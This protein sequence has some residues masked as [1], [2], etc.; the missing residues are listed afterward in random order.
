MR[1]TRPA[2][3]VALLAVLLAFQLPAAERS[4]IPAQYKWNLAD[5]YPS[6][7]AWDAAKQ[8]LATAIPKLGQWQGR[9]GESAAA[10]L[11]AMTEWDAT[12]IKTDRLYVYAFLQYDQ[13]RRIS[14]SQQ[15]K[16]EASQ[17][18]TEFGTAAAFIQ[19]EL[20][21]IGKAKIDRF[22]AE[23]PRLSP[24]RVFFD[25]TFRAAAHT[26][27]ESEEK[28]VART[29]LMS[30]AGQTVYSAFTGAEMPFPQVTLS[31]GEKVRIDAAGYI[32][33]RES[34]VKADR[35]AV[36]K[37][38][39]TSY[40]EFGS[41][42]ST[43]LNSHVNSLVF[44]RDVH[45]FPST[46][47][48]ALYADNIPTSVYTQL[49]ADVHANLPTLH[50]YLRL[51]QKIM[52]LPQLGYEDLYAP[53]V[54]SVDLEF[55]PEQAKRLTLESFAPLGEEYVGTLRKGYESGWVDFLPSTGKGTGAYSYGVYG[56]H[57][58]QLLNFNGSW[59][60]VS[61]LA[62]ESGHSMNSHLS[63]K[64]QPYRTAYSRIPVAEVASTLNENLLFH[65][66][67]GQTQDDD[68]RLFLLASYLDTMRT[69]IFRQA[70]FAEFEL[71]INQA[72][73][74]GEPLTKESL[75]ALYLELLRQYYGAEQGLVKVADLYA[76][77]WAYIPHFYRNFYVYQY[78]TGMVSGMALAENI[79]GKEAVASGSAAKGRDAYLELLSSGSSQYPIDLLKEAGVDMTTSRPFEAA[80]REM[81]RIMDEI[82]RIYA[83][84]R[85]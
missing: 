5:L 12:S 40:G 67:L 31:N 65:H 15:M 16:E 25:D 36:F 77:E 43:T 18:S 64:N 20:L 24:Y 58:Y 29:G 21:S 56:V 54:A 14:R 70:M 34:P 52:G 8:E 22:L 42:L 41:T 28:I 30:G 2:A 38:F 75:D 55:T 74:R 81:N 27:S 79:I 9:L 71:K 72:V 59:Q 23:E 46:L 76:T 78:A 47:E 17:V 44:A 35:D 37:A 6:E 50:R 13:D 39:F 7:A 53:I 73:E 1:S 80:M 69:T 85:G 45:K 32:K 19:P 48:A 3:A 66:M 10:L 57:P 26:L 62:H 33:Y 63:T 83:R 84:R 49:I 82:E 60:E 4:E 51:R 68:T 11:A 61:T